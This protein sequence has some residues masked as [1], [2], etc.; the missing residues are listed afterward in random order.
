MCIGDQG[1]SK[2]QEAAI[3]SWREGREAE[4]S[5]DVI[6]I[7][8]TEANSGMTSRAVNAKRWLLDQQ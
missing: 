5:A 6:A 3:R 1:Q 4:G 7:E 8:V 2:K